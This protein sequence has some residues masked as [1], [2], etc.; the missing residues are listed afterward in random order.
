MKPLTLFADKTP[1]KEEVIKNSE[2]VN[3]AVPQATEEVAGLQKRLKNTATIISVLQMEETKLLNAVQR[4]LV[5]E[6]DPQDVV[7]DLNKVRT[8]LTNNRILIDGL[9]VALEKARKVLASYQEQIKERV[10]LLARIDLYALYD[11]YNTEG[12]AFAETIRQ[13]HEAAG[14]A[15]DVARESG[16]SFSSHINGLPEEIPTL[17]YDDRLDNTEEPRY[18]WNQRSYYNDKANKSAGQ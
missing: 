12:A 1:P 2:A 5:M 14:K 3:K 16:L 13:V 6:V 8:E 9:N 17:R 11:R 7:A 4:H 10:F 15:Q 18:H